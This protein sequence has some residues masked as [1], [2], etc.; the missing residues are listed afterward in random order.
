[1][2]LYKG[3]KNKFDSRAS[4]LRPYTFFNK[5]VRHTCKFITFGGER[6]KIYRH[7]QPK[8]RTLKH[9]CGCFGVLTAE[10]EG[11]DSCRCSSI[12]THQTLIVSGIRVL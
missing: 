6:A 5:C 11:D 9:S 12:V 8:V 2:T 1:M 7:V 10:S 4:S 3:E